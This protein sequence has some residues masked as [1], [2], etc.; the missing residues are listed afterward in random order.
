MLTLGLSEACLR[1]V[2]VEPHAIMI[3]VNPHT[4]MVDPHA[5]LV[6]PHAIIANPHAIMINPHAILGC[7]WSVSKECLGR[8]SRYYIYGQPPLFYGQTLH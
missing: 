4:T 3:M 7:V 2:L 5:I 8:D 1:L 6:N